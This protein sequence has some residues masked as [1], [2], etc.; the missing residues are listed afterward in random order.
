MSTCSRCG[1]WKTEGDRFCSV[2]GVRLGG[3]DACWR[4]DSNVLLTDK[5]IP[6]RSDQRLF[7]HSLVVRNLGDHAI[8]L[9]GG[10]KTNI[11]NALKAECEELLRQDLEIQAKDEIRF[12]IE[13]NE[14]WIGRVEKRV[15]LK[16]MIEDEA[17]QVGEGLRIVIHPLPRLK[18]RLEDELQVGLDL[19]HFETYK[20]K[21]QLS[22]EIGTCYVQDWPK[23]KERLLWLT[24]RGATCGQDTPF[25]AGGIAALEPKENH[26]LEIQFEIDKKALLASRIDIREITANLL[27]NAKD[28]DG[29]PMPLAVLPMKM[30]F[31]RGPIMQVECE[32][33]GSFYAVDTINVTQFGDFEE[34]INLQ[35]KNAGDAPLLIRSIEL[36]HSCLRLT[37]HVGTPV[38]IA[39]GE[40]LALDLAVRCEAE[41]WKDQEALAELR[42]DSNDP[43][44]SEGF[45]FSIKLKQRERVKERVSL[46]L[47]FGTVA[48]VIAVARSGHA[49]K[50]FEHPERSSGANSVPTVIY[51]RGVADHRI[52][53]TASVHRQGEVLAVQD[54]FKRDLG[55]RELRNV[56]YLQD[57]MIEKKSTQ[58]I[59]T[60][61]L[62]EFFR[63]VQKQIHAEVERLYITHPVRFTLS[64]IQIL[65]DIAMQCLDL[66]EERIRIV[67]EPVAGSLKYNIQRA[68]EQKHGVADYN[69]LVF[70]FGGGTT[71][72]SL[73]HIRSERQKLS[74]RMEFKMLGISGSNQLGG[75]DLTRE[76]TELLLDLV[77]RKLERDG[78]KVELDAEREEDGERKR[79]AAINFQRIRDAAEVYKVFRARVD[80]QLKDKWGVHGSEHNDVYT[81]VQTKMLGAFYPLQ[82]VSR[83][84]DQDIIQ[85]DLPFANS[86]YVINELSIPLKA[87]HTLCSQKIESMIGKARK[88]CD[89]NKVGVVDILTV[90][91]IGRSSAYPL[92]AELLKAKFG[93]KSGIKAEILWPHGEEF[94]ECVAEGLHAFACAGS[95]LIIDDRGIRSSTRMIG[96]LVLRKQFVPLIQIGDEMRDR[97]A[98]H[99]FVRCVHDNEKCVHLYEVT[100]TQFKDEEVVVSDPLRTIALRDYYRDDEIDAG[101]E[102]AACID[103]S[104]R[105]KVNLRIIGD[106]AETIE[107]EKPEKKEKK[108]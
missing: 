35:I 77:R 55:S 90:I 20:F 95:D 50:M 97:V 9:A 43:V 6:W 46:I 80:A 30:R 102:I 78:V 29:V 103:A 74:C 63:G 19:G 47:D 82:G 8:L 69:V 22:C 45:L 1:A 104:G 93:E 16:L 59:S 70:D 107:L 89:L 56:Y 96:M 17:Q 58:D 76:M 26:G 37:K 67:A 36:R 7:R 64:Q 83:K 33:G 5:S 52:G 39:T 48:S 66:E 24:I 65:K 3:I 31:V 13:F 91:P 12:K 10:I 23:L 92:V 49:G 88:L 75:E 87:A 71:D 60:D 27:V 99:S 2:C 98:E 106:G 44:Y 40:K 11:P 4:T 68:L 51:Y 81:S 15:E 73:M 42:L 72:I 25:Q 18:L 94:K 14:S 32:Q 79:N 34:P 84:D 41:H 57:G 28:E 62:R 108:Q 38:E 101:I 61:Y 54:T 85:I 100:E 105:L 21:A 53:R 86:K